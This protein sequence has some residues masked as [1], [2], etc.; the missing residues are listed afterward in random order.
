MAVAAVAPC[1]SFARLSVSCRG[2]AAATPAGRSSQSSVVAPLRS[3]G[4]LSTP[5]SI[6]VARPSGCPVVTR[7]VVIRGMAE[8]AAPV[9]KKEDSAKKRARLAEV[10]RV[11]NKSR[12]TE[13]KTRMKKVFSALDSL[14]KN[15]AGS[16]E[17]IKPIEALIAEAYS[18]IDKSVKVGTL[19]R[20]TGGN[21][22]SRLARAKRAVE[23]QLGWYTPTPTA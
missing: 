23:M 9:K 4:F 14:K 13:I 8:K 10:R 21:R 7:R 2:T 6:S 18:I 1:A 17:E 12:K 20:N 11:Y 5:L 19:H 22:K 3:S 16:P 15:G